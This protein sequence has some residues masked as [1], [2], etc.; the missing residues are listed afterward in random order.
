MSQFNE[1]SYGQP[2]GQ[3]FYQSEFTLDAEG[4]QQGHQQQ[5]QYPPQSFDPASQQGQW[6]ATQQAYYP[7]AG[8]APQYGYGQQGYSGEQGVLV[9]KLATVCVTIC[10]NSATIHNRLFIAQGINLATA[11]CATVD[12]TESSSECWSLRSSWW[13]YSSEHLYLV[14]VVSTGDE[15]QGGCEEEEA[16]QQ[17][18]VAPVV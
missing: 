17:T 2:Y 18:S 10:N 12:S 11:G 6:G 16:P 5:Q 15:W 9:W 3:G 1:G 13:Q 8:A 7:P 14:T 4:M